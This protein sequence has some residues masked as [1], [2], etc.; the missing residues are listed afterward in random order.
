ML[1]IYKLQE[2]DHGF[3]VNG[4]VKI[5]AEVDVS[6]S[7]GTLNESEISEES[8]DLLSKKKGNDGN[9][10]DDLL[11][12]TLSVKESNNIINGTKQVRQFRNFVLL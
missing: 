1:P 2:E 10:S 8:S 12:K 9:E 11:K 5:I 3:L 4:E 6:E 7:A